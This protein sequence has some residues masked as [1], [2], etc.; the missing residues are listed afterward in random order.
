MGPFG[1]AWFHPEGIGNVISAGGAVD[2]G[3]QRRFDNFHYEEILA[4]DDWLFHFGREPGASN[5][6]AVW[7]I[8]WRTIWTLLE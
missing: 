6:R 7:M 2:S 4:K 5:L 1:L 3:W 8:W